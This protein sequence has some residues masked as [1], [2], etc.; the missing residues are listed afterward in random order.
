MKKTFIGSCIL[1]IASLG[2]FLTGCDKEGNKNPT[3]KA[4][5]IEVEVLVQT[6]TEITA[7][8][9]PNAAT[10][11]FEIALGE[12]SL[13][14][15]ADFAAGDVP[16][17]LT[18]EMAEL[19]GSSYYDY[20]WKAEEKFDTREAYHVFA[21]GKNAADEWGAV[22]DKL[23]Q[24]AVVPFDV[25]TQY[26][27]DVSAAFQ[28]N[29]S[30]NI[31]Q[32][33]YNFGESGKLDEFINGDMANN[34]TMKECFR[35]TANYFDLKSDTDYSF[36][37]QGYYRN[38]KETDPLEIKIHTYPEG[39]NEI[40]NFEFINQKGA[41]DM[42]HYT[43]IPNELC[44][45][46]VLVNYPKGEEIYQLEPT[47]YASD[48]LLWLDSWKNSTN[49][50]FIP[51]WTANDGETLEAYPDTSNENGPYEV[52]VVGMDLNN[53]PTIAKR[54]YAEGY[55]ID[56]NLPLPAKGCFDFTILAA[57]YKTINLTIECEMTEDSHIYG[58]YM[59]LIDMEWFRSIDEETGKPHG[60][61]LDDIRTQLLN[62]GVVV[63]T[64][65]IQTPYIFNTEAGG[66][67]KEGGEYAIVV[68]PFNTNGPGEFGWGEMELSS[69]VTLPAMN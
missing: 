55:E 36:Y 17:T 50:D 26:V 57:D 68:I 52:Y 56:E 22:A 24:P 33:V 59:D 19:N 60:E 63:E 8:F 35:W 64:D 62:G 12:R 49:M 2:L 66:G 44:N 61:N 18:V 30:Q 38:G 54:F 45:Q 65:Y 9:T 43:V 47:S 20:T 13:Y 41:F 14:E 5:V 29:L 28:F 15:V 10:K 48:I 39:S 34:V 53:V 7:R 27:S 51:S 67:W 58:Y 37:A 21:R 4:S 23:A 25:K 11:S 31:Y 42:Q 3:T 6:D 40:V 1:A 32:F 16:G 46:I 69:S